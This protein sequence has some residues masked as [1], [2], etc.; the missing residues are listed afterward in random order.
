MSLT[1]KHL[2]K[3][4]GTVQANHDISFQLGDGEC[5]AILGENGAGK[6]TMMRILYGLEAMDSGGIEVDGVPVEIN[7]PKDAIRLGIGMVH[8]HFMLVNRFTVAQNMVLGQRERISEPFDFKKENE[9]FR[10]VFESYGFSMELDT[11]VGNLPIGLQQR[12]EIV[13]ALYKG[14]KMLVLDEPT[15][16]LTPMEIRELFQIVRKLIAEGKSVIFISHKLD[17]VME[18]SDRVL[19]LRQGKVVGER[20][21]KETSKEELIR[22]MI[23]RELHPMDKSQPEAGTRRYPILTVK[24]LCVQGEQGKKLRDVTFQVY[25]HE[26]LG[27]AG[28]DGNGQNE[29]VE[30][31]TGL[32]R[33]QSGQVLLNDAEITNQSARQVRAHKLSHIPEDR[34]ARGL[35]LSMDIVENSI[36]VSH[37]R[38]PFS[39]HG[40][41]RRRQ[42][43]NFAKEMIRDYRIYTEN[44]HTKT[45]ALSGGNQQKVVVAREISLKPELLVAVKPTRGVDI[46]A[47][48]YIHQCILAEREKG[49]GVLLVSAELDEIMSLSD[50]IIVMFNG[51]MTGC[52]YA[53]QVTR[54]TLG[55]MMTGV[56][57]DYSALKP[58][59]GG[60]SHE[61]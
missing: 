28:V 52:V 43:D 44:E 21:T 15:A 8:Q 50:R 46:G 40:F 34:H 12:V 37:D 18:I 42:A 31:I 25:N 3:R 51:E 33:V 11:K 5:L 54:D 19:V 30:A 10:K 2:S 6:T 56:L 35:I 13:K 36:L 57:R 45:A 23:G 47:T 59:W 7:S 22:M 39:S 14:A 60:D 27:V 58:T 38:A 9:K 1:V 55:A 16:V 61:E 53:D 17:E 26:I 32:R 4:F 29:L 20:V 48:E 49:K 41:L 24:N